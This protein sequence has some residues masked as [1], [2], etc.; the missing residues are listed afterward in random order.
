MKKNKVLVTGGLGFIGSNL[1]DLLIKKK[2]YVINLDKVTYASNS[3][4]VKNVKNNKNYKFYKVD[5]GDQKKVLNILKEEKPN[6]IFNLAAETHVDRSIDSP[7]NFVKNNIL[8]TFYFLETLRKFYKKNKKL[9]IIHVSTDEV[10]GSISY[11]RTNE[12]YPYLPSSPYAASKA[13]A[14]H[15]VASYV[16]TF[17]L[18]AIITKCSNN[19][20]PRQ[21]PE[22]LIPKL[23]YNILNGMHLP[24]YGNGKNSRE[25]IYVTD[26]CNALIKISSIGKL[27]ESY[28]IGSNKNFNNL[29]IAK[30]LIKYSKNT[31]KKSNEIKIKYIKDR[32]GHDFR[33][34]LNSKKIRKSL[35]WKPLISLDEGLK[36]TISWYF[37]NKKF[38][39]RLNKNDFTKRL[40]TN[41]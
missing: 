38:Y 35:G 21:H 4:N 2:K 11:G 36:K 6:I 3:Y 39:N 13:S 27:G 29:E 31:S 9:K 14:D 10:Y 23:I 37:G 16:K 24:I 28:N 15:L 41:D 5:I 1:I 17:K 32:P 7:S 25:W 8:S 19:Y 18:P 12:N 30:L 40:G 34:A 33:Y 20:G 26:H 22:K